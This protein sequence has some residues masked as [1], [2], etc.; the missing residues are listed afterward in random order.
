M[1]SSGLFV[2]HVAVDRILGLLASTKGAREHAVIHFEDAY[3]FGHRVGCQP[4]L[5]WTCF[6]YAAALLQLGGPGD[7]KKAASL[8]DEGLSIA[9]NLGMH[10]LVGKLTALQDTTASA[11]ATVSA[12]PDGLTQREVE[13]LRL[14]SGGKTDRE[15]GDELFISVKTVGNHVSN[16]LNKTDTANRTEAA[17]YAARQGIT[18]DPKTH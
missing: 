9:T 11:P 2:I 8:L 17:V 3:D 16:I 14:I 13:V 6:E 18:A 1:P 15:I 7:R 4:E 5:G 10:P 12:Y